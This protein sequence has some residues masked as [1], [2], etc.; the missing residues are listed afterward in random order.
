MQQ[1]FKLVLSSF[2]SLRYRWI[3]SYLSN[4]SGVIKV[5]LSIVSVL[6]ACFLRLYG[7]HVLRQPSLPFQ[8]KKLKSPLGGQYL[9]GQGY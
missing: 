5:V 9:Q 7:G 8:E 2:P 6:D 3:P 4:I 1:F